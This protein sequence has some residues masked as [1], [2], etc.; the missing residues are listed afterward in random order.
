MFQEINKTKD[1]LFGLCVPVR[2]QRETE[3]MSIL[4]NNYQEKDIESRCR[5]LN[6]PCGQ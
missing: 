4:E 5:L 3:I 2:D 6:W 1:L